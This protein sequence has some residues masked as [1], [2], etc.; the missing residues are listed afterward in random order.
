M[1]SIGIQYAVASE[2]IADASLPGEQPNLQTEYD[3][4]PG[5]KL[6][7]LPAEAA[8]A[9]KMIL[10]A[11]DNPSFGTI[12]AVGLTLLF[13]TVV[14]VMGKIENSFNTIWGVQEGRTLLRKFADYI[15]VLI[16]VPILMLVA[17]SVNALLS[18]ER[19][20]DL[21]QARL[22]PFFWVYDQALGLT[23]LLILFLAFTFLYMFMPN[24]RVRFLPALAG[25]VIGGCLWYFTQYGYF[26][27]QVGLAKKNAIYGTLA[28]VPFFLF[29][30]YLNWLIVLIGAEVAFAFQ[31]F[32]TYP[33]EQM[34]MQASFSTRQVLAMLIVHEACQDF[35]ESKE[36]WNP[37]AFSRK[38]GIPIRLISSVLTDLVDEKILVRTGERDFRYLPAKD[39]DLLTLRDV[40]R[41]IRGE[42][43]PPVQ[44]AARQ[45]SPF[46]YDAIEKHFEVFTD[47]LAKTSFR[48]MLANEEK[49]SRG[50]GKEG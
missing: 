23:S 27:L 7:E 14:K 18:S 10:K 2:A 45:E 26:S 28:A 21:L 49:E 41:A 17:T 47:T 9:A 20:T 37:E 15:S 40:E 35:R 32:D 11:V 5:S 48:E 33:L 50:G 13:W 34:A 8:Q 31:N 42:P 6:A 39:L 30:V 12:G 29:W 46:L 38:H 16:M 43:S 24:T 22:G 25:A 1:A 36:R 19:V 3:V 44:E 4:V